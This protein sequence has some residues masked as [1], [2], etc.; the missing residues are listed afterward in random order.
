MNNFERLEM[1]Q[2]LT[3]RIKDFRAMCTQN[4]IVI[5]SFGNEHDW[6]SGNLVIE[7][8]NKNDSGKEAS[9]S[10]TQQN[11]ISYTDEVLMSFIKQIQ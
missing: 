9:I 6:N 5:K 4:H 10:C 8:I 11:F 1:L 3:K 2:Q 7:L